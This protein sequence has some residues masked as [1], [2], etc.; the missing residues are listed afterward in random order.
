MEL[1]KEEF[2]KTEFG[3]ELERQVR[4]LESNISEKAKCKD[5]ETESAFNRLITKDFACLDVFILAI[6]QFYGIEYVFTRTDD[7]YGLCTEDGSDFLI[8]IMYIN[9]NDCGSGIQYEMS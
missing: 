5:F 4:M 6:K 7:Y 1:N 3:C 8:K 9:E 2:L